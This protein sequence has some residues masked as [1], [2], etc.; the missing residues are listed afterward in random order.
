MKKVLLILLIFIAKVTFSQPV[1]GW[2]NL[3]SGLNGN[4][5]AITKFGD[6]I[7]A[8][9]GFTVSGGTNIAAWNGT[10]WRNLGAGFNDT[11]YALTVYN[12]KL[13]AGGAFT[14]SGST[15]LSRI[16]QWNG[17]SWLP[18]VLGV[19]DEVRAL[20]IYNGFLYVGGKF[21]NAG[22]TVLNNVGYW[23]GT[24]WRSCGQGVDKDVYAFASTGTIVY[25]AGRFDNAGPSAAP[26]V[27][28]WDGSNWSRVGT[29]TFNERIFS[30][31]L[32]NGELYAGGRFTNGGGVNADYLAKFDGTNWVS[33]G[34]GV[35]DRIYAMDTL[36]GQL[37]V[38]G[39]QKF[40][41][42][43][44]SLYCNRIARFNG[45]SWST[46]SSGMGEKV[47]SLFVTDSTL[48]A[49][50]EFSY[51]GGRVANHI[52]KW[53]TLNTYSI[54][55]TVR[56][57]GS[58]LPVTGGKVKA[59]R[60]DLYT[61]EVLSIDSTN[62][63]IN[64]TFNLIRTRNDTVDVIAFPN[65][66]IENDFV[67]TYYPSTISWQ[68]S[69]RIYVAGNVTNINIDVIPATPSPSNGA[70]GGTA[71]LNYLPAGLLNGNGL[72]FKSSTIIYAKQGSIYR[73]FSVSNNNEAYGMGTLPPGNYDIIVNRVGYTSAS[74]NVTLSAANN[75]T[76]NNLAFTL[77]PLDRVGIQN[78]G[79]TVSK[80]FV[81]HQNYPNPFNPETKIR[82]EVVNS[83]NVNITVFDV[84][85]K[86]V[87]TLV[88]KKFAPGM[89][90][91]S[92]DASRLSSG[93]YFYKLI[94]EDFVD[95]KKM[96]LIR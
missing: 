29:A 24:I 72:P 43:G 65:D 10:S 35:E 21:T 92:F 42:A 94:S 16:A 19:D 62:I 85:G 28:K 56:Y 81:L 15:P 53:E 90:E 12:G 60:L 77:N 27:A 49:G 76:I 70:I 52:A 4:V 30:L 37:V 84:L 11:V 6:T 2:N 36:K 45:T 9:G 67:P 64:G 80:D 75:F 54:T 57:S 74:A 17:S 69:Q 40:V 44:N 61:R 20:T 86:E 47:N 22:S 63:Q 34:G 96:M 82:F 26:K 91:V 3:G 93:I 88:N 13:I 25:A 83:K 73:S 59:I 8:A 18:L 7:I 39:Q 23:D 1:T 79:T 46:F 68:N 33:V 95:T 14:Q 32:Y 71:I 48:Y 78:I 31:A 5:N 50:G 87:A 41:G 66:I 55:G 89:Y 38:G 58:G 51:A